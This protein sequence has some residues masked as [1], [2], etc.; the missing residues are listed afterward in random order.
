MTESRKT[1]T[2]N[3]GQWG[4]PMH[5]QEFWMHLLYE[6]EDIATAQN[7]HGEARKR[8]SPGFQVASFC[9]QLFMP[10]LR[11]DRGEGHLHPDDVV[12]AFRA[13]AYE[14]PTG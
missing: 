9:H 8:L 3:L 1:Y 11:I 13:E 2:V 7:M 14:L 12:D 4:V 10:A 6:G 5:V